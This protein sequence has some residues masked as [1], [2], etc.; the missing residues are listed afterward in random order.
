MGGEEVKITSKGK[1]FEKFAV[2]RSRKKRQLM[3]EN[4]RSREIFKNNNNSDDTD[5]IILI[6]VLI[7]HLLSSRHISKYF[8]YATSFYV[9]IHTHRH[10]YTHS[11]GNIKVVFINK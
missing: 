1:S 6:T 10:T 8:M 11:D 9:Q 5:I 3:K 7:Q 4:V 2:K